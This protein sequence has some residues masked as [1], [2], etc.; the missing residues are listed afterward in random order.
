MSIDGAVAVKLAVRC[1]ERI[2]SLSLID[3]AGF[4]IPEKESIYDEALKGVNLFQVE[5]PDDYET[6]RRCIFPLNPEE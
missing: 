1:P 2:K 4:Y 5:T 6:F 3:P